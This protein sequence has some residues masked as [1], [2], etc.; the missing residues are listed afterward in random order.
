MTTVTWCQDSQPD[1]PDD[2]D[3]DV[4]V[5]GAHVGLETAIN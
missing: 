5:K 3:E 1:E 4:C 2:L